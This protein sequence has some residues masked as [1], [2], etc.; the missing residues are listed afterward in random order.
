MDEATLYA[1]SQAGSSAALELLL[2]HS[3]NAEFNSLLENGTAALSVAV[4]IQSIDHVTALLQA[5]AY[6]DPKS[7]HVTVRK[8]RGSAQ[9]VKCLLEAGASIDAANC[10]DVNCECWPYPTTPLQMAV[11]NM[12]LELVN[13]LLQYGADVSH[14]KG[15]SPFKHDHDSEEQSVRYEIVLNLLNHGVDINGRDSA[16]SGWTFL[17]HAVGYE[18]PDAIELLLDR[19]ADPTERT[20]P[21]TPTLYFSFVLVC[22]EF[23]NMKFLDAFISHGANINGY[24]PILVDY[25]ELM[26]EYVLM[27]QMFD[28][29]SGTYLQVTPLQLAAYCS[30]NDAAS[31]LLQKGA[32]INS[33]PAKD[34]GFTA[35]QLAIFLDHS[36]MIEALLKSGANINSPAA[37][38]VGFTA[39]QAAILADNNELALRLLNDG[40][41]IDAPASSRSGKT[42]LQAAAF[43]D[44][45]ELIQALLSRNPNINAPPSREYGATALQYASIRGNFDVV[46]Q[47][48]EKGADINAAPSEQ[49]GR[50]ALQGAA[51]H[52]RLDIVHLLLENDHNVEFLEERC[53]KAAEFAYKEGHREIAKILRNWE[54]PGYST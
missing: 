3:P 7:L 44:N 16:K 37:S 21:G 39:L 20:D 9:I 6:P 2:F 23:A 51:E 46:L 42:S 45:D 26:F 38:E 53:H 40:A 49:G 27:N 17:R 28:H 41:E 52:G 31:L 48:L 12:N 11:D 24:A 30:L 19:G 14:V 1:A 32:D 10:D 22:N 33:P 35:L 36:E 34:F 43:K 5:G 8:Y 18:N 4:G 13:L 15:V 47:L 50:T 29:P 25:L 54:R